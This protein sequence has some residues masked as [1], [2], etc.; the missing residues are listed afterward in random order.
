CGLCNGGYADRAPAGAGHSDLPCAPPLL[1]NSPD[2]PPLPQI[3]MANFLSAIR[4]QVEEV[5]AAPRCQT[6]NRKIGASVRRP[7]AST[8]RDRILAVRDRNAHRGG[9][10]TNLPRRRNR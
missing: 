2:L 4:R 7:P 8:T 9:A 10:R 1:G 5:Y 6:G 3:N